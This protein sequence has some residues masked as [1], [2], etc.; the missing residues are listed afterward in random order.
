MRIGLALALALVAS[1]SVAHA[2]TRAE[3]G[4]RAIA[5]RE[6]AAN[7]PRHNAAVVPG[8]WTRWVHRSGPIFVGGMIGTSAP[9]TSGQVE[10]ALSLDHER[11]LGEPVCVATEDIPNGLP[12]HRCRGLRWSLMLGA[13]LGMTGF[14][15]DAPEHPEPGD[16]AA[17][18]WGPT[19]RAHVQLH[20]LVPRW[21]RPWPGLSVGA[22]LGATRAHYED[23]AQGTGLRL[24]PGPDL[25]FAARL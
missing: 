23:T 10:G 2:D 15:A 22:S 3:W 16:R 25:A 24:E 5:S 19:A 4:F 21:A 11:V 8:V 6:L 20:V 12:T 13:D 1:T 17:V 7:A 9:T 18:L 14:W